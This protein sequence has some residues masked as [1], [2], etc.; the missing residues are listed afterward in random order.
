MLNHLPFLGHPILL[1]ADHSANTFFF[2][3]N[4]I[5]LSLKLQREF[6]GTFVSFLCFDFFLFSLV[7]ESL[8][9]AVGFRAYVL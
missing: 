6:G 9:D 1:S 5:F 7:Q 2:F 3:L 8:G 4:N